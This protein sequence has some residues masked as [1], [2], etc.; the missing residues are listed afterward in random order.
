M[1]TSN[2]TKLSYS[3]NFLRDRE[4]V[5]KL[6]QKS[7]LISND[8]VLEIGP[9]KGIIT[10]ILAKHSKNVLAVEADKDLYTEL[11]EKFISFPNVEIYYKNFLDFPL[12][13]HEYKVFSNIPFNITADIIKK[14]LDNA[15]SPADSYLIVQKEAAEKY[16]GFK[17]ETLFSVLH[18]PWFVFSKVYEFQRSDFSPRPAVDTVLFKI[19]K[20]ERPLVENRNAE[21]FRDF[22]AFGFSSMKVNLKKGYTNVFGHVQFLRLATDHG[23]DASAKPTDLTFKQWLGIFDYFSKNVE[24]FRQAKTKGAYAKLVTQQKSLQK[25]HR[26]RTARNWRG[27]K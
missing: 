23:F 5:E 19:E 27:S 2:N 17:S 21:A 26:T 24:S 7:S 20:L 9:G 25:I 22:V 13:K 4:L 16:G 3:Q 8:V 10:S 1:D 18:K 6:V 12:P 14:L 11:K 15:N